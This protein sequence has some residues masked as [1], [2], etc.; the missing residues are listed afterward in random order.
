MLRR[1]VDAAASRAA[2]GKLGP[3]FL[4]GRRAPS[5]RMAKCIHSSDTTTM[6]NSSMKQRV[7]MPVRS[8]STPKAIGRTKPP[9]PPIMPTR[10][11]T[12]PTL[13]GIVDR[14]VLE[15]R[16]LAQGHEEAE[17]EDGHDEGD[18][19]HLGR[20]GDRPVD[21]VDDV[22]GRRIGQH[23][24]A[25]RRDAEGQVHDRPRAVAVRE[26]AAIDAEQAGRDREGGGQHAGHLDVEAVDA[27][28]V[29]RQPERQRDEGAE[30]EEVVE[31]EAP[32]LQ[33]LAAAPAAAACRLA[34]LPWRGARPAPGSSLVVNQKKER[35]DDQ[36]GRPDLRHGLPAE[37]HHHEGRDELG[38]RR[39]DVAGAEDAERRALLAASGYHLET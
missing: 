11:P 22:V 24:G 30:D 12:A 39:A 16:R 37:G 9:R 4:G 28:Q 23:E 19:A 33:V 17:H 15:D 7:Q 2:R 32:D 1:L 13:L 35:H 3:G 38:H 31:R 8:S 14:D 6:A 20:E 5:A 10:P 29:A 26:V 36:R 34:L 25:D 21:A 27:D 18:E